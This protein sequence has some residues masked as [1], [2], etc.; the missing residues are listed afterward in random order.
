MKRH[1]INYLVCYLLFVYELVYLLIQ[2]Q[3]TIIDMEF[4]HEYAMPIQNFEVFFIKYIPNLLFL[5]LAFSL[6]WWPKWNISKYMCL[7]IN[8]ILTIWTSLVSA[9]LFPW[10]VW[11]VL[12]YLFIRDPPK[13]KWMRNIANKKQMLVNNDEVEKKKEKKEEERKEMVEDDSVEHNKTPQNEKRKK[14]KPNKKNNGKSREKN[15]KPSRLKIK[16]A[17]SLMLFLPLIFPVFHYT[18][19]TEVESIQD[20]DTPELIDIAGN[21]TERKA[22]YLDRVKLKNSTK[23]QIGRVALGLNVN[24][25]SIIKG[26]S[27]VLDGGGDFYFAFATRVYY[28]DTQ[29][30]ILTNETRAK[31]EE[32]FLYGKFWFD[33]NGPDGG[34][35]NTENHQILFHTAEL[36]CGQA[37]KNKTFNNTDMTGQEHVNHAE[38]YINRWLDWRGKYG[39][40]EWNSNAY[41]SA[42]V[43]ALCNIV[44]FAENSTLSIKATMLMDLYCLSFASNWFNNSFATSFG[45]S[46][47]ESR[48]GYGLDQ[49]SDRD[50]ISDLAWILLGLGKMDNSSG[51]GA[52]ALS[53]CT[54]DYTPPSIFND[55]ASDS[56]NQ[57]I[58]EHR[59][60]NSFDIDKAE[61]MGMT[62]S[63]KDISFWW[64]AAASVTQWTVDTS[65]SIASKYNIDESLLYGPGVRDLLE[66]GASLRGISVSEY[67]GKIPE[68]TLGIT[69]E[70]SNI[71]TYRTPY[72]QLSGAQDHQ[73]GLNGIQEHIWQ[74]SLSEYAIVFT[75]APGGLNFKGGSFMGGWHPKAT[76]HKNVGIMQYDHKYSA[77]EELPLVTLVDAGLNTIG[78]YRPYNHAYF[79]QWAF[80][81]M[82]STDHWTFGRKD[83]SYVALYSKNPTYWKN[84]FELVSLGKSN[85]WILE[86]GSEQEYSSFTDFINQISKSA[87]K[88]SNLPLGYD[89]SYNSPSQGEITV[90]WVGSM[91]ANGTK[92]DIGPYN[93]WDNP[94]S[95]T[96]RGSMRTEISF[97]I[98][99]LILDF[100]NATRTLI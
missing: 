54:S 78:G 98:Q 32:T 3:I 9:S 15:I 27:K 88:I 13:H 70:T 16:I 40:S 6:F 23:S 7:I 66:F 24:E 55:I 17:I 86:L 28:L 31:L 82:K 69:M 87:I 39:F 29:L 74:A 48:V 20:F 64:G 60:S 21:F 94:Y 84:N 5:M 45:R 11:L 89:V 44:D 4:G 75:N 76:F 47:G 12:L 50:G 46:Y 61:E 58:F 83:G 77:W 53:I 59:E 79:P 26:G 62:Y 99:K 95:K 100:E 90:G 33:Q 35:Y 25:P 8:I 49:L 72:Y 43:Q 92:V 81:E 2:S 30:K 42:I 65:F 51:V 80:D 41:T 36:L 10:I 1:V 63:E 96:P 37:L 52:A 68:I 91:V 38:H 85:C 93:R 19:V 22:F 14:I 67:A 34:M 97:G 56:Q 73:K 57:P 71:Y 18:G